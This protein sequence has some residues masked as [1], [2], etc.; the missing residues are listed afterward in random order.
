M[1][2]GASPSSELNAE[3]PSFV[4]VYEAEHH[5]V[6]CSLRRLDIPPQHLEDVTH[7]VFLVVHRKLSV[8][9]PTRP[10]KPW[11]FGIAFRV[12]SDFRRKAS[13]SR[14]LLHKDVE[15]KDTRPTVEQQ[16]SEKQA[17]RLVRKVLAKLEPNRRAIMILHDIDGQPV[18]AIAEALGVPLNTAYS[19]LRLAREQFSKEVKLLRGTVEAEP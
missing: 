18:P 16:L 10:L 11:L 7:D 5:Y 6:W 19:R 15:F 8:Y 1:D 4:D 3:R 9:D 13:N 17:R 2:P 14:E 12:A